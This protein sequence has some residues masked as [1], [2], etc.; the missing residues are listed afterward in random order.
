MHENMNVSG[1]SKAEQHVRFAED[2]RQARGNRGPARQDLFGR[3]VVWIRET[4]G[5]T[6]KLFCTVE[7]T[8]KA[9]KLVSFALLMAQVR[10]GAGNAPVLGSL[11][12]SLGE[13]AKFLKIRGWVGIMDW[14]AQGRFNKESIASTASMA[15]LGVASTCE[16]LMW[17]GSLGVV[18]LAKV[19]QAIGTLP[20]C[21]PIATLSIRSV[22]MGCALPGVL[23]AALSAALAMKEGGDSK[24]Q[25]LK[26]LDNVGK[27][28][29]IVFSSM[30]FSYGFATL[31]ML[32]SSIG[33][34]KVVYGLYEEQRKTAEEKQEGR[35]LL[36]IADRLQMPVIR[37]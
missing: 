33:I 21:S 6:S 4:V 35:A 12:K 13:G 24:K 25:W 32:A 16:Q 1:E 8:E 10:K 7:G 34:I 26:V 14:F 5:M 17:M 31:G 11:S 18:N 27:A 29:L 30:A 36:F 15:L 23:L 37:A 22:Y 9:M 3:T 28:G 20:L 19:A 2:T